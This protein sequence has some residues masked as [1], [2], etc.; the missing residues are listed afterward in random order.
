THQ[1]EKRLIVVLES[2]SLETAKVGGEYVLL[3]ADRH[4]DRIKKLGR[5]PADYRPDIAHQCLLML[6]D[7]PLNRA[8]LLQVFVRTSRNVLIQVDPQ[9]RIPRTYDRFAGLMVQLLH[10]LAI[11]AAEGDKKPHHGPPAGA[12]A[13]V[14]H[15]GAGGRQ[16]DRAAEPNPV[17]DQP[18]VFVI[19][20]VA[21]GSISA[22]Y[23][24]GS[25]SLSGYPLS[26]AL[27]CA[28]LTGEFETYWRIEE[29]RAEHTTASRTDK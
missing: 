5:D 13:Q 26:A 9:T 21:H 16:P 1:S 23:A 24:E 18:V 8:G 4:R 20:A 12:G 15:L 10:K 17:T 14:H 22:D 28:K 3:Q 7:S 11:H 2:A 19:G 27:A 6:Q 29:L 25:V